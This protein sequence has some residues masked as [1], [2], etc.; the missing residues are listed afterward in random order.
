MSTISV[1]LFMVGG[2]GLM[3]APPAWAGFQAGVDAYDRGDYETA[4]KEFLPLAEQ[5]L[6]LAQLNLGLMHG[7]GQ[8]VPKD[9]VLA[10]MWANLAAAQGNENAIKS[11][12]ILEKLMTTAQLAEAQRLAREWKAKEWWGGISAEPQ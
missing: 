8:G 5:G 12:D 7:Q 10:H 2:L 1:P 4:L 3:L 11:R 9:Y 6:A